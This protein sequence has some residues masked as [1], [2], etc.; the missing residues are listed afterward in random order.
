MPEAS[1]ATEAVVDAS[2]LVDVLAATE[3]AE[4]ARRALA[5]V[6][7]HA[8]AHLD[9]EVLGALGRLE[10]AGFVAAPAVSA[11]LRNLAEA[12]V[13]RHTLPPLLESAWGRRNDLQLADA[14]YVE[15]ADRLGLQLLTTDQRLARRVPRAL[16]VS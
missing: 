16:C 8:P 7:M 15:L 9:A 3:L 13:T 2:L 1:P 12:P 10:R 4:R 5:G 6:V 14:L 11:A